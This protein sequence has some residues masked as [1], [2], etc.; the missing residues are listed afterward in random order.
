MR[1]SQKSH[2]VSPMRLSREEEV[3]FI[4]SQITCMFPGCQRSFLSN[5]G[6]TKHQ[7]SVHADWV[8]EDEEGQSWL[9]GHLEY[10]DRH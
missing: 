1:N 5:G 8:S 7:K 6:L 4:N 9:M 3:K 10:V 2:S